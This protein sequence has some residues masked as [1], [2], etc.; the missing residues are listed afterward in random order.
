MGLY[1]SWLEG[2]AHNQLVLGSSPR[3][4]TKAMQI[5]SDVGKRPVTDGKDRR[6]WVWRSGKRACFGSMR[7]EIRILSPRPS[8]ITGFIGILIDL[9]RDTTNMIDHFVDINKMIGG[10][11]SEMWSLRV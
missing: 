7:P 2:L 9:F 8:P 10:H 3:G 4:P 11:D 6:D 1:L 5:A